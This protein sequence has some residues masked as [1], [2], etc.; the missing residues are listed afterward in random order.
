TSLGVSEI[1]LSAGQ[2][3]NSAKG[4]KAVAAS[5]RVWEGFNPAAQFLPQARRLGLT[6]I[7][8]IPS[9][10]LVQGQASAID[11][12]DGS[13]SEMLARAP[14]AMVADLSSANSVDNARGEAIGHVRE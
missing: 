2:V 6:T 12:V 3:D 11:L 8:V 4:E 9:G 10:G 5:F 1:S 13:L 7:G 14:I